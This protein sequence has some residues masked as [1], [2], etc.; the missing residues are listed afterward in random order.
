M[1]LS[2]KF[3]ITKFRIFLDD[4]KVQNFFRTKLKVRSDKRCSRAGVSNTRP[5]RGSNA[6]REHQKKLRFLR[7]F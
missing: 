2:T 1:E 4:N 7:K 6:A 5:A 3:V